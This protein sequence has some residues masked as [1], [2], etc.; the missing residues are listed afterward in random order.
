MLRLL[1]VPGYLRKGRL[2]HVIRPVWLH[3]IT[4]CRVMVSDRTPER[5]DVLDGDV[6]TREGLAESLLGD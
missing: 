3:R 4:S 6:A 5:L 2:L 1:E